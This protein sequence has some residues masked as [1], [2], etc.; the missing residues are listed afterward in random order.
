MKEGPLIN[1]RNSGKQYMGWNIIK[2]HK[3]SFC[4]QQNLGKLEHVSKKLV[5]CT[6]SSNKKEFCGCNKKI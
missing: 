4:F 3:G 2:C 1:D 6:I 5:Y